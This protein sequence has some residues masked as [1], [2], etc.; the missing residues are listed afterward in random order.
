MPKLER[1]QQPYRESRRE[2]NL[3]KP[4]SIE[5]DGDKRRRNSKIVDQRK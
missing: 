5:V 2:E 3:T 1:S 4:V